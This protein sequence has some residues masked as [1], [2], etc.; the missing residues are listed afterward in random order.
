MPRFSV[1]IPLYNKE[2]YILNALESVFSQSF[3]DFELIVVSDCSI[4][5]SLE[6]VQ[7]C[8][9]PRIRI[10][11]HPKNKGLAASR[12][13]GIKAAQTNYMAFLDADDVWKP[14]FL[15]KIDFLIRKYPS[16]ALF[17]TN[18]EVLLKNNKRYHIDF[19]ITNSA[20]H[21]LISNFFE[22]N[23]TQTTYIPSGFCVVK[24]VFE[25]IGFYNED[26]SYSEDVDFNI[27]ANSKYKLAYYNEALVV[28][29]MDSE[30]QIT[31]T[32]IKGKII[33][34][35]D[36]FEALFANRADIKK[37]LDYQRYIKAKLFKLSDDRKTYLNLKKKIDFKNLTFKQRILIR[38]P[39]FL[40]R[41][42]SNFKIFLLKL[43][44]EVNSY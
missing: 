8:Q 30:N 38:L 19:N 10:I 6:I 29:T 18:Y 3:T 27:R 5:R 4:D 35:Y 12:N 28:Y 40:L 37:Y 21:A 13:T 39:K 20:Q 44:I 7:A 26:I 9:D 14:S 17:A 25:D 2:N 11:E 32:S 1:I 42:V 31:Q 33:P 16:A 34:D 23:L 24:S 36:Y 15:E 41:L 22:C 43:G